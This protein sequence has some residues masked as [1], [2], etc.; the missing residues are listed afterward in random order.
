VEFLFFA[1]LLIIATLFSKI[2]AV[3][4]GHRADYFITGS[5]NQISWDRDRAEIESDWF[6][7]TAPIFR[8]TLV[9]SNL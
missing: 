4:S 2:R 3:F 7:L 6:K 9:N 5:G 8:A 1:L